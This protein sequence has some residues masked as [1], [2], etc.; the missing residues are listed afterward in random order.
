MKIND[1]FNTIRMI[2]CVVLALVLF[3]SVS[4]AATYYVS[5]TGSDSSSGTS[6][7]SPWKTV[8]KVNSRSF[9]P[10]D[11]ILFERGDQ[12][13][14]Q[15]TISSSG[16]SSGGNVTFG[17]YGSGARP[18]L[19][20]SNAVSSFSNY[21]TNTWRASSSDPR[22]L[23][24]VRGS[25]IFWGDK[26]SSVSNLVNEYDWYYS[27]GYLYV[28]SSSDPDSRYD[29]IEAGV[30]DYCIYGSSYDYIT[31]ENLEIRFT[32]YIAGGGRGGVQIGS[33]GT[34]WLIQDCSIHHHGS[35]SSAD[36]NQ[37]GNG[38]MVYNGSNSVFRRNE[39]SDC[40][41]HNIFLYASSGITMS[42]VVV[43]FNKIFDSSHCNMDV[44]GSGGYNQIYIRYNRIYQTDAFPYIS[45]L[46]Y[47]SQGNN[48]THVY[49]NLIYNSKDDGIQLSYAGKGPIYIYNNTFYKNKARDIKS[50][51]T[52]PAVYVRN[53]IFSS[54]GTA[55]SLSS[56]S[57]WYVD[58]NCYYN[59]S[60]GSISGANSVFGN[61]SFRNAS[62]LDFTL[63]SSSPC[64][65]AGANVGSTYV[66]GL[67]A[68][69]V[70]PDSVSIANQDDFGAAREIG[71][72]I[73]TPDLSYLPPSDT[74]IA[75]PV[76]P[77]NIILRIQ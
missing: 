18:I 69:S 56:T 4:W 38:I 54:S 22:A 45:N 44:H 35:I 47:L 34:N 31:I 74:D 1:V 7:G 15:L 11:N 75:A 10:G 58:H 41:R 73:Y 39:I 33:G 19:N 40:G 55:I 49:G 32:G 30:R 8:S 13:I 48:N 70:W 77:S 64:I 26:K 16:S 60:T 72:Y 20:G 66:Q 71:A 25:S 17:A 67:L 57:N 9:S 50:Y 65:D 76:S 53:N 52:S 63:S 23:W 3:S 62:G 21:A 24:F 5:N 14:E 59:T 68:T 12:W 51:V 37:I 43:E 46:V 36:A 2:L 61:P 27:G 6:T 29:S 28:Y 42:N